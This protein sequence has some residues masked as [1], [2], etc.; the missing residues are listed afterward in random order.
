MRQ[1]RVYVPGELPIIETDMSD[2]AVVQFKKSIKSFGNVFNRLSL[3]CVAVKNEKKWVSV[4][5]CLMLANSDDARGF[6]PQTIKANLNPLGPSQRV[7]PFKFGHSISRI[8][9]MIGFGSADH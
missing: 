6:T 5:T 2:N 8:S 9:P 1:R 7:S 3:R 4:Y